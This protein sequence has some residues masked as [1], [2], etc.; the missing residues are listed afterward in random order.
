MNSFPRISDMIALDLP[1]FRGS[2][3][4]RFRGILIL[5]FSRE[6]KEQR[7]C[8]RVARA[9]G[10]R[11]QCRVVV[12]I[13]DRAFLAAPDGVREFAPK[14]CNSFRV[15]GVDRFGPKVGSQARQPWAG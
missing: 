5:T 12:V 6:E 14:G 3:R 11:L 2:M 9:A 8:V 10:V 15:D 7:R 4:E 13:P 1:R